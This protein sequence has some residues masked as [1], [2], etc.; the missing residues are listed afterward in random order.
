MFTDNDG[1]WPQVRPSTGGDTFL[2][3]FSPDG[4][5]LMSTHAGDRQRVWDLATRTPLAEWTGGDE[6][7]FDVEPA[8][9][10]DFA[11]GVLHR[12]D[13]RTG[14]T[15][16]QAWPYE[17]GCRLYGLD[18]R[19]EYLVTAGKAEKV[20]VDVGTG[21]VRCTLSGAGERFGRAALSSDGAWLA[22][23]S[24]SDRDEPV[25]I[26]S[27]AD[28]VERLAIPGDGVSEVVFLPGGG[29]CVIA[30]DD[31]TRVWDLGTEKVVARLDGATIA[32]SGDGTRLAVTGG[33]DFDYGFDDEADEDEGAGVVIYSTATWKPVVTLE[34]AGPV[35]VMAFSPDGA[36]L[37]TG[38]DDD[39]I[40]RVWDSFTGRL[41]YELSGVTREVH[42]LAFS[43]DGQR[44]STVTDDRV[45]VWEVGA[46]RPAHRLPAHRGEVNA[47]AYRPGGGLLA[48][49]DDETVR[50]WDAATAAPAG[51]LP[52]TGSPVLALAYSPDGATLA[53]AG[54]DGT[55]HLWAG[56]GSSAGVLKGQGRPAWYAAFHPGG[57][58]LVVADDESVCL[59]D[60]ATGALVLQ[61]AE[62]TDRVDAVAIAPDGQGFAIG[63]S[64][65]YGSATLSLYRTAGT[66][67]ARPYTHTV[68]A[69]AYSP[70]GALAAGSD[71][72]AVHLFADPGSGRGNAGFEGHT[73]LIRSL[74]YSPDGRLLAVGCDNGTVLLWDAESRQ[75]LA[76]LIALDDGGSATVRAGGQPV[77]DGSPNGEFWIRDGAQPD[78]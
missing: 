31:T 22:T 72:N 43:A 11:D 71:D 46:A 39:S 35:G 7:V 9:V 75:R 13:V 70:G 56:D 78:R 76:M 73:G 30:E 5:Y 15:R 65:E 32:L 26:W 60:I 55:I 49:A 69:L 29:R 2:I 17:F 16:S 34:D 33:D 77:V 41:A 61:L 6:P 12:T 62:L 42:A 64:D 66:E 1:S 68:G 23:Y 14:R 24:F 37:A 47:V 19:L 53:T 40:I 48:V 28:G 36:Y 21:A 59:W 50:F 58:H 10:V 51:A 67:P 20:L 63:S 44:L 57:G 27:T 74:A 25:R 52:A 3:Q 45:R 4:R 38:H 54:A 18:G 8:T